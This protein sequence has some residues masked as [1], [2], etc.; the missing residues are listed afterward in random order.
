MQRESKV[1]R[2]KC[3][4]NQKEKLIHAASILRNEKDIKSTYNQEEKALTFG[5]NHYKTRKRLNNNTRIIIW[6][7][8]ARSLFLKTAFQRNRPLGK[9]PFL[10]FTKIFSNFFF[11]G[12]SL[13]LR[14][15]FHNLATVLR[16]SQQKQAYRAS[17][18][19]HF[20]Y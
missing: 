19:K 11:F 1:T 13:L 10:H 6:L 12:Q 14:S 20:F 7:H 8:P 5:E 4:N 3:M 18:I 9:R 17:F 16:D 15:G 2:K